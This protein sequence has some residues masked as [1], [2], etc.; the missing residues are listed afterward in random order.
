MTVVICGFTKIMTKWLC[1]RVMIST[2]LLTS[3][4][5]AKL[6]TR[7]YFVV[8]TK[9]EVSSSCHFGDID[10]EMVDMTLNDL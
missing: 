8:S 9:F 6:N 2:S 7:D 3:I 5:I 10:A 4:I 1:S